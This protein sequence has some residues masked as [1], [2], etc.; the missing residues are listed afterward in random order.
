MVHC[1]MRVVL[2]DFGVRTSAKYSFFVD[3]ELCEIIIEQ[4]GGQFSYG[5][6]INKEADTPR[7]R[8][9]KIVD[10]KEWRQAILFFT[11]FAGIVAL[12]VFLLI[13]KNKPAATSANLTL[14]ANSAQTIARVFIRDSNGDTLQINYSFIAGDRPVEYSA[15]IFPPL[16]PLFPLESGDEFWVSYLP[17]QPA[18]NA[19]DFR[20]PAEDQLRRY[21]QRALQR[22]IA[23]NP[24]DSRERTQCLVNIA[25][26]L[27]AIDGLADFFFQDK[28]PENHP[29]HNELTFKRLIRDIPFTE[30][31]EK[32]CW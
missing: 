24:A 29:L 18:V 16:G 21:F 13:G 25:F 15:E 26:E 32:R 17:Q 6:E 12:A 8:H 5:F 2:I 22:H 30:L 20:R 1:N 7:N 3:D 19:I 28:K 10:R 9:R 11:G 14:T 23:L 27:K 31:R 4:K